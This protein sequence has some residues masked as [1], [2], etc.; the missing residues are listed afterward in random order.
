MLA[1]SDDISQAGRWQQETLAMRSL[2][3][4]S[5]LLVVCA[6]AYARPGDN[7][8]LVADKGGEFGLPT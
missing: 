7:D 8:I 1:G 6:A 5:V 4:F 3:R 2:G